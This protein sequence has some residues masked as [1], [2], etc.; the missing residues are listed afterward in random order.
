[1]GT[2]SPGIRWREVKRKA[3]DSETADVEVTAVFELP[4]LEKIWR[5]VV[6]HLLPVVDEHS[7]V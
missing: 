6:A 4:D 3:L 5:L 2:G 7:I 1:V